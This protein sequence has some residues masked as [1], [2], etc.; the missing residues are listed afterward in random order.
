VAYTYDLFISYSSAD[1]AW[2]KVLHDELTQRKV[3]CF[4][5]DERLTKGEKWLPQ[6]LG[7][8]QA[9]RHFVVLW[10]D[11]AKASDWVQKELERYQV[12]ID[13]DAKGNHAPD[14]LLYAV[15]LQ[16]KNATLGDF[17]GFD[18]AP[19]Q[20]AYKGDRDSFPVGEAERRAWA[21]MVEEIAAAARSDRVAREIPVAV[22]ALDQAT[23]ADERFKRP[24]FDFLPAGTLDDLLAKLGVGSLAD[25]GTR[26]GDTALDWKPYGKSQSVVDLFEDL[27]SDSRFGINA[28][29]GQLKVAP[30]K[31]RY[32]DLLKLPENKLEDEASAL[33]TESCIFVVDPL[34]FLFN[35][36]IWKRYFLL[37]A[38]F[39]SPAAA[40]VLPA[41][42][43]TSDTQSL[44]REC[45]AQQGRPHLTWFHEPIPFRAAHAACGIDVADRLDLRRLVLG[46]LAR[47]SSAADPIL[48][49]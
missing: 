25:V 39:S 22:L 27:R 9:S 14:R 38:F 43:P 21:A 45:I 36:T 4:L 5:D 48:H 1:R 37:A 6:L 11:R 24:Q 35:A 44:L 23:F 15:N 16:G 29:L 31:W 2:A 34:S 17:Q 20:S 13:P 42:F 12:A 18:L 47:H 3:R 26:Y 40:V 10:S 32:V 30:V 49:P 19:L 7:S 33:S 46:S 41:P 8:L 28:K